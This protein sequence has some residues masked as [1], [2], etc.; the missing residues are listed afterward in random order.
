MLLTP[1]GSRLGRA[2]DEPWR[3]AVW[4]FRWLVFRLMFLSGV[5][6]LT[7]GDPVWRAW[8]ALDYHY[9]TQP[10]PTWTSWY[11]HQMP[12]VVPLAVGRV[13]VLR[14][15]GRA[16]LRLRAEGPAPRSGSPAWCCSRS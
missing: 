1:W 15:A 3:F 6:K 9:Q 5:V 14:R 7:S 10:L 11:I 2:R 4:L 13:H 16:V 12:A 8:Q